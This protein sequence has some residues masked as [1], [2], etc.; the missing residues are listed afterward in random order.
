MILLDL[1]IVFLNYITYSRQRNAKKV[2]GNLSVP[3]QGSAF[4]EEAQ[5]VRWFLLP[6]EAQ[7]QIS[8]STWS[9]LKK[10]SSDKLTIRASSAEISPK[11]KK[12]VTIMDTDDES[13]TTDNYSPF[14]T[15]AGDPILPIPTL[16][17]RRKRSRARWLTR[18]ST[19]ESDACGKL[20]LVEPNILNFY[21]LI[22]KD[23]FTIYATDE[24]YSFLAKI[25]LVFR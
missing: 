13:N 14:G 23:S 16:G 4:T 6:T 1:I 5:K 3:D 9:K 18:Q 7:K 11:P 19:E 15:L 22:I 20:M 25:K 12:S 21:C 10:A 8:G 2:A 17:D 24:N